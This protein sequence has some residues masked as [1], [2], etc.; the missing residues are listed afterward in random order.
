MTQTARK[1]LSVVILAAGQGTRM[2][3][4]LPKVL[5]PIAGKAMVQ[6]VIDSAKALNAKDIVVVYGHGGDIVPQSIN[7]TSI[8]FAKQDQ[9]LGTGHAVQQ[10]MPRVGDDETILILYGD[11]PLIQTDTLAELIKQADNAL[12]LLSV[13]LSDPFGYGR[14]VR[15][16][17]GAVTSIVEQKDASAAQLKITEGNTGILAANG[18]QLKKWLG[19]LQNDNAQGEY[20][21]T[22]V[23]AMAVADGVSINTCHPNN[24]NEVLGVNSRSQLAYLERCY[25]RLQA[26]KLMAQ[27]VTII[28]PARIDIRG[29]VTIGQDVTLDINTVLQGN[30]TIADNVRIGANCVI[31][32]SSIESGVEIFPMCVIDNA[33]VGADARIGPYSRLRPGATLAGNNH[34][35]NFVEIKNSQIG[36][37]SK[38]NHL[39][40]VGDTE[41]GSG[42][43]IGAGTITANYDGANKHKTIIE[44]S[45]STGSNS[46]LVAPVKIAKGSTIGAGSVITKDTPE[47]KLTITRAKQT[48]IEGW[49]RPTKSPK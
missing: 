3:S 31:I 8:T 28:D 4:N 5:H 2:K 9:Q 43:N 34:I 47:G 23:I 14:I 7:D 45:A 33:H 42:V 19:Q 20:Y 10:A 41:M 13:H 22:D 15:D 17:H 16:A 39:S 29:N 32:D 40:Y 1:H 38:V 24:E 48:V 46:V 30:V 18:K 37:G 44:D 36:L 49:K 12:G 6:H 27:G 21:L 26:E 11:V 25:Q 35:G